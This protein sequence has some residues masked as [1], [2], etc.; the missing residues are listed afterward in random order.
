MRRFRSITSSVNANLYVG[1]F[2]EIVVDN[3]GVLRIQD[4]VT[5]G[6]I[7]LSVEGPTGPAGS[8]GETGPTGTIGP[9]G[10]AGSDGGSAS[11]GNLTINNTTIYGNAFSVSN[12]YG[13]NI[14]PSL[15][16]P[17][18]FG[19]TTDTIGNL[20]LTADESVSNIR[21]GTNTDSHIF[22]GS[23]L[24][25]TGG[26]ITIKT[27]NNAGNVFIKADQITANVS[28]IFIY[29]SWF[30]NDSIGTN[31][32]EIKIIAYNHMLMFR[33]TNMLSD[34]TEGTGSRLEFDDGPY[35]ETWY[36]NV[37]TPWD[38]P[39]QKSIDIVAADSN[40]Y[41]EMT[42]WNFDT[43]VGVK[44]D[45]AFIETNW[46]ADPYQK[47][48]FAIN[49][50][51]ILPAAGI[52][53]TTGSKSNI[54]MVDGNV[55][56]STK[57][58]DN[59]T[60]Y[61]STFDNSGNLIM[62]GSILPSANVV[63][64]LGS[65]EFQWNSLYVS[66]NTIYIGG[67][68]LSVD[69]QG[70]LIVNGNV[71]TAGTNQPYLQLTNVPFITLPVVLGSP[72]TITAAPQGVNAQYS[73][74]IGD[75]GVIDSVTVT[76]A[77]SGYVV[78]Q[79]Y[80]IPSYQVGGINDDSG[81][82]VVV[83]TVDGLGELLTVAV[84][85][86]FGPTHSNTPNTYT[87]TN[88]DYLPSVFDTIDVGLTLTRDNVR[89]LFNSNLEVQYNT[90]TY[91]SPLGTEWNSDGWGD[92]TDLPSRSYDNMRA[93]LNGAI[94]NNII[95]AELVMHDIANDKYYK[96]SFTA[97]GENNGAY[98]YTRNLITDP[99]FFEKTDGGSEIDIF[100]PDD[101]DGAG[102]GITRDSNNGIY[103]PYREGSW[104]SDVSPGGTLW[105][106]DGLD[107]LSN[108][109]TRNYQN[110]FAAFG[111]G[112]LGLKVP[113]SKTVMYIPDNGKYYAI[114]WQGW[115]QNGNGGG[116]SYLRREIDLTKINTGVKFADGT[117]LTSAA[118]VGRVKA[119]ASNGRR[120]EEVT[121]NKTVSVTERV[122]TNL[123]TVA[124]RAGV[125]TQQVWIDTTT[126]TIDDIIINPQNYGN[127]YNF[128]FSLNDI[129]WYN[130]DFGYSSS[131]NEIGFDIWPGSL[132]Y[133]QGD[134]VYFRYSTGGESV[135]W[136]DKA[137][138]PGGSANFRGA[139]IDYHAYTG[140]ST[141][142]GTIH[143]VDDDGEENITHTEVASGSTD[144]ENDD[145]WVV[146]NEGTI[147]YRRIDGESKT[148]KT[149]WIAKIFY[150]TEYYD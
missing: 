96:F 1:P 106:T 48:I 78:D 108:L 140:E 142:I 54:V 70:D 91:A 21:I 107:D 137:D 123:T 138:L 75:G 46:N 14:V 15:D 98:A 8:N 150:G 81:I 41:V 136:W 2:G 22:I 89:G 125:S 71:V 19:V 124:S 118:G 6:G 52:I 134:T 13:V 112:G 56:I 104:D 25:N 113:G 33:D 93:V 7:T 105:N 122:I 37:S 17:E 34:G 80:L 141:I 42:S 84:E 87:N 16:H 119:T 18:M 145:L 59:V 85:G 66:N 63:Y 86:F 146:Q 58:I 116:F 20:Q 51:M 28:N 61:T 64:D 115:T 148:L 97:W 82:I 74:V 11:L 129:T 38:P 130:Y 132:T 149:Q 60:S 36:G 103:N 9:T 88:S 5:P 10:P 94:G 102:V 92:L 117:V 35:M 101:G 12:N 100:I 147:S 144:G 126:T 43:Y 111:N 29:S 133:N 47:W 95:G 79:R 50:E 49:G 120:I 27:A 72:V 109:L 69:A 45:H 30:G 24:R 143:I 99:N 32:P 39:Y 40:S 114:E 77:G 135:V 131:G 26:D 57:S 139:I 44:S 76:Q 83:A 128:Q 4:N 90:S 65:P 73:V 53:N 110:F 67:V 127:A 68:P 62:G 55:A 31:N 121:G 23:S 3:S